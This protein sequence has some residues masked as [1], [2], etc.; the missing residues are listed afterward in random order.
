MAA[1]PSI[2]DLSI[3]NVF[4]S[5]DL[6]FSTGWAHLV[7]L[8][9]VEIE[10]WESDIETSFL[11]RLKCLQIQVAERRNVIHSLETIKE[12]RFGELVLGLVFRYQKWNRKSYDSPGL[13]I[14]ER[15]EELCKKLGIK[16]TNYV[17]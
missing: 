13:I 9:R 6:S 4:K 7:N 11:P 8:E 3:E 1:T 17:E 16:L 10:N 15:I 14:N 5:E 12:A 2:I